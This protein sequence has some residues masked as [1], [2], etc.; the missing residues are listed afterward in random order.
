MYKTFLEDLSLTCD[1]SVMISPPGGV[2][3]HRVF[4]DTRFGGNLMMF[5]ATHDTVGGLLDEADRRGPH[6]THH[7]HWP[8]SRHEGMHRTTPVMGGLAPTAS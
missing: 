6:A 8:L 1:N 7:L 4:A 5:A 3:Y 2:S